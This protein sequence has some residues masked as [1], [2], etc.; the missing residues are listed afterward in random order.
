MTKLVYFVGKNKEILTGGGMA[1]LLYSLNKLHAHI[2]INFSKEMRRH[3]IN[4][5]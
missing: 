3:A 1:L 5:T 2:K 4:H